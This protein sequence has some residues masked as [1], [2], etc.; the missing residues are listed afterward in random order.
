MVYL[1]YMATEDGK[2]DKVIRRRIGDARTAF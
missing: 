2:Y 1:G